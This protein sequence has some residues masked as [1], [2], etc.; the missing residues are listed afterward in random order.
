MK[1][2]PSKPAY[3]LATI[4]ILMGVTLFG[5]GSLITVSSL[6]SKIS[7]SQQEGTKA[8]YVAEAG[9]DD[10][11][12]R[13]NNETTYSDAL[14]NGTL[15]TSYSVTD[16]P[17]AGQGFTV[18]FNSTAPYYGEVLV[19]GYSDNGSFRSERRVSTSVFQGPTS[20]PTGNNGFML[21]GALNINNGS[22]NI[23][24]HDGDIYSAG[25]I[26]FNNATINAGNN[27]IKTSGSYNNNNATI[28]SGGI[29][30]SNQPPAPVSAT[31]PG[32]DFTHYSTN[33]TVKYTA[34]QF[35]NLLSSG[36]TINLPGPI[37]YVNG[38]V[39]LNSNARNKTL[40][41]TGMLI[42]NG[43]FT[44]S[45][46]ANGLTVN[47]IDPG[48]GQSGIFI[49]QSFTNTVGTWNIDGVLYASGNMNFNNT[50]QIT[51][52]G[53]I[54]AGG[55]ISMNTGLQLEL[56]YESLHPAATFGAGSPL[57]V[58]VQHWEEEY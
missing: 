31:V 24:L 50:Q 46:A 22:S 52:H 42:I 54:L 21:G 16:K 40:N 5:V 25:S 13:L 23:I 3:A 48:N 20:S 32:F 19:V 34:T 12:W 49:R 10:A 27:K 58:G 30:S 15:N 17:A 8:Y 35:T 51:I 56:Y 6:E 14:R 1:R 41:I 53:A 11:L 26:N 38:D 57:S 7:R 45:N 37:T 47:V 9:A 28:T 2:L 43:N 36:S 55:S 44:A 4:L 33:N 29:E 39:V 18:T